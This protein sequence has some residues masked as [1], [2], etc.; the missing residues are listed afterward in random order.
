MTNPASHVIAKCGGVSE[1]ARL[2]GRDKSRVSRWP[3]PKEKGGSGGYIP[4]DVQPVLIAN[5]R[6]EGI[7]LRP[8][9][10]FDPDL[11][12]IGACRP[13]EQEDAA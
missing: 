4:S 8:D 10:F 3:A 2:S 9:D 6:A 11:M 12:R 5:A 13:D 1:T 7:D